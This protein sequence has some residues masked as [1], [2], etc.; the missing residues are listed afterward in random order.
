MSLVNTLT[1]DHPDCSSVVVG[2]GVGHDFDGNAIEIH[3][4]TGWVAVPRHSGE[5]CPPDDLHVCPDHTS[6]KAKARAR[7]VGN[8]Y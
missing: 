5:P 7:K 6:R 2:V 3:L 8:G 1:C 4:P